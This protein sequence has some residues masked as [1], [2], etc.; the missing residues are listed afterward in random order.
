MRCDPQTALDV[1]APWDAKLASVPRPGRSHNEDLAAIVG[2]STWVLDGASVL[3]PIQACC[4]LDAY[5]YVRRLNTA[6]AAMLDGSSLDL[7]SVLAASISQV[8]AEH[9]AVCSRPPWGSA[10]SA[11]VAMVRRR[12]DTLDYL[13]LG[14]GSVLLDLG[15]T[16]ECLSDKRLGLVAGDPTAPSGSSC[17]RPGLRRTRLQT[18]AQRPGRSRADGSQHR[19]W[20]LDCQ[21]RP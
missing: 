20:V 6:L 1:L 11:T 7:S 19:R 2:S 9:E 18:P 21:P 8:A 14:D 16:I 3:D 10:P 5:W 13:V 4:E 17:C 15:A 12:G